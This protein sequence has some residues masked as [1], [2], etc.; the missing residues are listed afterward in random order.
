MSQDS[1]RVRRVE[2]VDTL[3]L[4]DGALVLYER[5]V[6][7]LS[8]LGLAIMELCDSLRTI[9]ELATELTLVFGE[10]L[11]GGTAATRD[12]VDTL[13]AAGVL[14]EERPS[15]RPASDPA[16]VAFP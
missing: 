1:G 11:Q 13:L 14:H 4:D 5:T 16:E 6:I 15:R 7:R 9:A 12:V 8:E 10:P 2:P 3:R